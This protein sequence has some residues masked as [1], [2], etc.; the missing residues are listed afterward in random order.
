MT[1]VRIKVRSWATILLAMIVFG[2]ST[3]QATAQNARI[4]FSV[5]KAG[6]ILGVGGGSGTLYYRNRAHP[7]SVGGVSVGATIGFS[8]AELSGT[9][10]HLKRLTDIEGTYSVIGASGAFVVGAKAVTLKN[11]KG[12]VISVAG[13]QVGLEVSLNLAGMSISLQ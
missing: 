2:C 12:V 9:V 10:S 6:L 13:S 8:V 1:E 4:A 11:N 7:I 5:V 3:A